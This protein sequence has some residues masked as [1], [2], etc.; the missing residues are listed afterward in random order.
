MKKYEFCTR[1]RGHT[2]IREK[3]HVVVGVMKRPGDECI[4]VNRIISENVDIRLDE[5]RRNCH[6]SLLELL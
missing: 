3:R 5:H 4:D 6:P 1:L 2:T